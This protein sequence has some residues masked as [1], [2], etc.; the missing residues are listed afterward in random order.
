MNLSLSHFKRWW[1][2]NG[3]ASHS[4]P[5][6]VGNGNGGAPA[7]PAPAPA[8]PAAPVEAPW[9]KVLD[10]AGVPRSLNYPHTTLGR[11]LDQATERYPDV[12][13]LIYNHRRWTYRELLEQVNRMAGGLASLG[14][15]RGE[16]VLLTLPNCPESVISFLAIQKLGAVVV[17]AGPLMG[18]DDLR[19]TIAMTSPR[20]AIGLDLLSPALT[21]ASHGSTI[22]H[23]VWVSLQLYQNVIKRVGYQVKL[24]Q[25]PR[26]NGNGDSAQ[27]HQLSDLLAHS[28]ARPPSV[29]PQPH[30]TAI[31]Q[32]TG[33]TTGTLKLAQLSHAGI[34]ANATQVSTRMACREGQERFMT[35]L[36][37]FHVYG[38]TLGLIGPLLSASSIVMTTRFD[39][40]ETID[41]IRKYKPTIFPLVPA[42]CSAICDKLEKEDHPQKFDGMRLCFSGAAP[43]PGPAVERFKKMTGVHLIEGYGLT[44]ASPVT[45]ACL[46]G[47][48]RVCSI[49]LPMPDTKVRVVDIDNPD[50]DV[51][52]GDPG[53]MLISGPQVM[54]GYYANPEQTERAL[55]KD[56]AGVTWL[57]TGDIVRYDQDGYF[58]VMDRKKDMIIRSGLKVYPAR[59]EKV[60]GGHALV[61]EVA[62]VGRPHPVHTQIV[63]AVVVLT[64]R[65]QDTKPI[66]AELRAL[67]KEHLAHYEVPAIF[68]F[69]DKLPRSPLG[70]LLKRDLITP[71][72]NQNQSMVKESALAEANVQAP[73]S[74][75]DNGKVKE[76]EKV[77]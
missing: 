48:T 25:N 12:T 2:G 35:V 62:V 44:E 46:P 8:R 47:E 10:G 64:A 55:F 5:E 21:G 19:T 49:G 20:V 34:L 29:A 38:L 15:R 39:A 30:Q 45:H 32:P 71:A 67:C 37:A 69:I 68:E 56:K 16:R 40:Q 3:E 57:R 23:F 51:A 27:H 43:L 42:I 41:L 18:K 9:L 54:S 13:A 31:L 26:E 50:R 24:W 76:K 74:A 22:E 4:M 28:P 73:V 1:S 60:L 75:N 52:P 70:K 36:P 72:P 33:G 63:A 66:E 77:A 61:S 6:P 58:Y 14:V 59:V 53:E 65:P 7:R 17:N 11:L